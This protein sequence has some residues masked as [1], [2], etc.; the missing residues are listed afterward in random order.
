[1]IQKRNSVE[2]RYEE[3]IESSHNFSIEHSRVTGSDMD[4]FPYSQQKNAGFKYK[5]VR[6]LCNDAKKFVKINE[7]DIESPMN[8]NDFQFF[9]D[10]IRRFLFFRFKGQIPSVEDF[11]SNVLMKMSKNYWEKN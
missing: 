3:N 10:E 11:Y 5:G 1:M 9:V 2:E 6:F 4:G 7:D 8:D